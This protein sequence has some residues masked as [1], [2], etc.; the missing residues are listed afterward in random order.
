M[1]PIGICDPVPAYR[2]GLLAVLAEAGLDA[3][4]P[5]DIEA[6]AAQEGRRAALVTTTF[7]GSREFVAGLVRAN[8]ALVVIALLRQGDPESYR[9]AFRSGAVGAVRWDAP[10]EFIARVLR[11]GVDDHC[12]IPIEVARAL[13]KP[14]VGN[15]EVFDLEPWQLRWL[16]MLANGATITELGRESSYSERE[17]FRLLQRVYRK[18]GARNRVDAL[19]K[20]AQVG[21]LA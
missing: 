12:M 17:V 18:M 1:I 21:I 4:E 16:R 19:V 10:P 5:D 14:A 11:S 6:W 20:A 13:A 8:P 3:E 15:P 9:E 2:R 7:P